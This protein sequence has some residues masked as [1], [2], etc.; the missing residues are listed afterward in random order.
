PQ[1][2][3]ED[4]KQIDTDDLEE[5][6]LKWQ[7]AMLTMRAKRFLQRIRRNLRANGPTSMGFD[8]SKHVET[9]IL[10]ASPKPASPKPTSNVVTQSKP[11][12]FTTVRLVSTVVPKIKVT[13]LRHVTPIITKTH[14]PIRRHITRSPSL[15]A[16]NS[17]PKVT[18][19]K[20]SVVNAA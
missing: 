20:A 6:D 3:N 10:A 7:M 17:P 16:S 14:L 2:D 12:H 8:M 1:L 9:F 18:A 15:K 11:V 13:R 5:M 4:L 19:V